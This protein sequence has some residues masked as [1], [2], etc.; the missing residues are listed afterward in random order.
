MTYGLHKYWVM[1]NGSVIHDDFAHEGVIESDD[2][3][4]TNKA[5]LV[6]A[7]KLPPELIHAD[8]DVL[9]PFILDYHHK[10]IEK[11][12]WIVE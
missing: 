7:D 12:D 8:D 5:Y 9:E 10:K 6:D 4:W 1:N 3:T 2:T 11:P